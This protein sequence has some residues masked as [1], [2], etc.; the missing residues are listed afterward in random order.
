LKN[1]PAEKS[2]NAEI[3]LN[4]NAIFL[5]WPDKIEPPSST[6]ARAKRSNLEVGFN[7][8]GNGIP[9]PGSDYG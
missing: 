9:H 8:E 6:R 2:E 5:Q 7:L 3:V 4:W 1:R